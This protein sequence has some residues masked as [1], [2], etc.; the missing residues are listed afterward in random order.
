MGK[1]TALP[2]FGVGPL[3]VAVVIGLTAA[4]FLCRNLPLFASGRADRLRIPMGIAGGLLFIC[5]IVLWMQ[6]VL[7]AKIDDGI[8]DGELVT[9]GVYAWVRNPIYAA[10]MIACTGV[11]LL[12]GNLFF[13]IL[14]FVFWG[15]MT[16]LMKHTEEKWLR[17]TF[18]QP[19]DEY[20]K[21]V[22]RCIPWRR[23]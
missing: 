13:L 20:C 6:A 18:G 22:N 1:K 7:I 21:K 10:F 14:P 12:I 16:V 15:F 17:R 2:M 23:R 9:H 4:A 5:G 19:Y 11:I 3:Y 8:R